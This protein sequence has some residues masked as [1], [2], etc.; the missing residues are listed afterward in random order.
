MIQLKRGKLIINLPCS[1]LD[2]SKM[3]ARSA[4]SEFSV[5]PTS[6]ISIASCFELSS[7]L[8]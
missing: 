6:R 1:I 2:G 8:F 7:K 5:E 3:R 4:S